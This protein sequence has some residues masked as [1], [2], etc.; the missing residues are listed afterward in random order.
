MTTADRLLTTAKY[1]RFER[2]EVWQLARKFTV[3]IY[4][5]TKKFPKDELFGLVSQL[6]RAAI[7]IILNIAEGSD[8][9]SDID[10]RRF[11]RISLS[12]LEEVVSGLY[13]SLDQNFMSQREFE[14]LYENANE[15]AAKLNALINKLNKSGRQ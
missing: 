13:I 10:F 11:L 15:L 14:E 8:R 9:K 4:R 12:S 5:L 3:K 2:L 7:S 6:R 1:F